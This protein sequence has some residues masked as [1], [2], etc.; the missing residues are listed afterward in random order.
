MFNFLFQK[1][2]LTINLLLFSVNQLERF[3]TQRFKL[4]EVL[5]SSNEMKRKKW[6]HILMLSV[7]HKTLRIE[8]QFGNV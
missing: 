3:R 5:Q 4:I 7:L 8:Y 6:I 2:T 1:R